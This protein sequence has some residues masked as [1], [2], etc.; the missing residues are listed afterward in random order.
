MF[1]LDIKGYAIEQYSIFTKRT[2]KHDEIA[3]KPKVPY[4]TAVKTIVDVFHW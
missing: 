3:V 1:P 2:L 4:I